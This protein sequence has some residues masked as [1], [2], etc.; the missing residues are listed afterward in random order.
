M[1]LPG[2]LQAGASELEQL[3]GG[4]HTQRAGIP[5]MARLRLTSAV[6]AKSPGETFKF[7]A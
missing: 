3:G 4:M 1:C 5:R 6:V 7:P 2:C